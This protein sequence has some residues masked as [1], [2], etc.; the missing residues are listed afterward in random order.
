ML[1]YDQE[2]NQNRRKFEI[3]D[4]FERIEENE[5]EAQLLLMVI[6]T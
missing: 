5:N 3:L 2:K 1:G 6:T 4:D